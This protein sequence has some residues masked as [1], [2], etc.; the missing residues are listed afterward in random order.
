MKQKMHTKEALSMQ[1]TDEKIGN[2]KTTE[3]K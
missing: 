3:N 2:Y 1:T